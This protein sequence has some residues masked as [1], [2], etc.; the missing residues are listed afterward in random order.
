M[1][2]LVLMRV[3]RRERTRKGKEGPHDKSRGYT[4]PESIHTGIML[5]STSDVKRVGRLVLMKRQQSDGT[6]F[7]EHRHQST[8]R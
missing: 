7:S 2:R 6:D 4:C 5:A 1:V 8:L 3:D